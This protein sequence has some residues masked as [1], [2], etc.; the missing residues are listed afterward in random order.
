MMRMGYSSKVD[1]NGQ[2]AWRFKIFE[3][4]NSRSGKSESVRL[5]D[6]DLTVTSGDPEK[7]IQGIRTLAQSCDAEKKAI[8]KKLKEIG[9]SLNP[10]MI[11]TIFERLIRGLEKSEN[12]FEI[13]KS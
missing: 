2:L 5:R 6:Y 12:D 13:G 7:V 1:T 9:K 10:K 3:S 4:V 11:K 8:T